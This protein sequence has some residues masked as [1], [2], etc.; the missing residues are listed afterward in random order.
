[1]ARLATGEV[2]KAA[3]KV[4]RG[5]A[6]HRWRYR[7]MAVSRAWQR[8]K[9]WR[10]E[11]EEMGDGQLGPTRCTPPHAEDISSPPDRI[12]EENLRE[13]SRRN[14]HRH[15]LV[16]KGK[17]NIGRLD[18]GRAM[19]SGGS[20]CSKMQK[21]NCPSRKGIR[22]SGQSLWAVRPREDVQSKNK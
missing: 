7:A 1:M 8:L 15:D 18:K 5:Q 19:D 2:E 21:M 4:K 10:F 20:E 17:R 3:G 14:G 16:R 11:N 9:K 6:H 22:G 13:R 12:V